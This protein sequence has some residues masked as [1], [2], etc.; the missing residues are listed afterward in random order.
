M[1]M[2]GLLAL[3]SVGILHSPLPEL[4]AESKA[5]DPVTAALIERLR[6]G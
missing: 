4:R 1:V 2:A 3:L 6:I 5:S